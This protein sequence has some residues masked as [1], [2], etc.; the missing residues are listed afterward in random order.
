MTAMRLSEPDL[1]HI[2]DQLRASGE[3]IT[4]ARRTVLETLL[5]APGDHLTMDELAERVHRPPTTSRPTIITTPGATTAGSRSSSPTTPSTPCGAG[6][7]VTTASRPI[8]TTSS[9]TASAATA[10]G[11]EHYRQARRN[12]LAPAL[13]GDPAPSPPA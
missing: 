5:D 9:S 8:P 6:S 13:L 12:P 7:N 11:A 2:L 1:D 10:S 4:T 3:R